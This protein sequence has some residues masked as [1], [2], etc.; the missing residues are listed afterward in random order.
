MSRL[1]RSD[2]DQGFS[3][4]ELLVVIT[5][6][7]VLGAVLMSITITA[8]KTAARQEDATRTLVTAKVAMERITREIRGA[9]SITSAAPQQLAF[10]A[11]VR[12][13]RTTTTYKVVTAGSTSEIR[14]A[15]VRTNLS[16][17]A[18]TSTDTKVL[19]GLAVGRS[20][21]VFTYA[22]G[23]GV[24]LAPL[25]A[26]PATY[27]PG[28]VKTVGVQINMRRQGNAPPAQLYQL[29]SIRNFEV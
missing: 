3:L 5:L 15:Q 28:A 21:I 13:V 11:S 23:A 2:G 7:G 9:N 4:V 27:A 22:D 19:G 10:V 1:R 24:A 17:G 8:S 26:S 14:A 18:S 12:G 16:T 20:D 6:L 25:T 29:V